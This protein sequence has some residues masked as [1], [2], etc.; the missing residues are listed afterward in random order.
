LEEEFHKILKDAN[1]ADQ[2]R[3]FIF[4]SDQDPKSNLWII[5]KE[6]LV[7]LLFK[8]YYMVTPKKA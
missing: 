4:K 1:P 7:E 8:S 2:P 3:R 6:A 5:E